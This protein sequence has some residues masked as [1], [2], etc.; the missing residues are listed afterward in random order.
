MNFLCQKTRLM[1]D[2]EAPILQMKMSLLMWN[3]SQ[4]YVSLE[5][6][7]KAIKIA[8]MMS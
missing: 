3:S 2:S 5:K 8:V 6:L 7:S 4:L 1:L